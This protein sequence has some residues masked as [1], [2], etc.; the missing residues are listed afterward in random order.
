M[1]GVGPV[2]ELLSGNGLAVI[3]DVERFA[4]AEPKLLVCLR[5]AWKSNAPDEVRARVQH[6]LRE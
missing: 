4:R 2:E 5:A 3:D 6:L 1:I